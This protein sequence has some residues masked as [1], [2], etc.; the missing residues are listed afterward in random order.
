MGVEG[1]DP[2]RVERIGQ[3]GIDRVGNRDRAGRSGREAAERRHR[4]TRLADEAVD[5]LGEVDAR[6]PGPRHVGPS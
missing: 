2:A 6:F 3:A 5:Q 4:S 1:I